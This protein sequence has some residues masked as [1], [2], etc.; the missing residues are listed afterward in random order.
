MCLTELYRA[1]R[2]FSEN[3]DLKIEFYVFPRE[4]LKTIHSKTRRV[5]CKYASPL[6]RMTRLTMI[7]V[8]LKNQSCWLRRN[9]RATINILMRFCA[10]LLSRIDTEAEAAAAAT[11]SVPR[12]W[13]PTPLRRSVKPILQLYCAPLRVSTVSTLILY[14]PL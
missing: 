12:R 13:P 2:D 11:D 3:I 10:R 14:Q 8:T 7:N 5:T 1:V 4:V 9:R 6:V